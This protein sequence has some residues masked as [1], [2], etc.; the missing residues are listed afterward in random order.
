[1]KNGS[2]PAA[3]E[4]SAFTD[5]DLPAFLLSRLKEIG[6][7]RPSPIQARTIP[8]LLKGKDLVG[9]AQTGTGKTAAFAL[10]ALAKV[11]LNIR[12]PQVLV[13][14][15]TRELSM[16][17]AEAFQTYAGHLPGFSVLPVY[18]GQDY[19]IQV[20]AI[21]RGVPV[22]VGTPGRLMDHMRRGM[23]KL[24]QLSTLVLDEADEMLRMGFIDDVQWI[25]SETPATR[26]IA[27]FSATMPGPI[28]RIAKQYLNDPVT[29]ELSSKTHT[30]DTIIQRYW[31]VQG[32]HKVDALS[33]I[34]EA[35]ESDAVIVFVRTK[36]ATAEL[37][38]KLA[39]RGQSAAALNG[40]MPQQQR[41]KT[42]NRLRKGQLDI[43]VATDVAARGLDVERVSHVIN[44]DIPYDTESYVHRIGRT[45][46]AGREGN[47]ILF[48]A[49]RER[50]MLGIIE[51]AI[52]KR[53][54]KMKLPTRQ[55]IDERRAARLCADLSDTIANTDLSAQ[56]AVIERFLGENE[57][58][59]AD[60][61]AALV[62]MLQKSKP[63]T[64]QPDESTFASD[65]RRGR[66]GKRGAHGGDE[67]FQNSRK[68]EAGRPQP[69]RT[70]EMPQLEEGM[71]RFRLEVGTSHGAAAGNIVGAIANEAGI[72]SQYIGRISIHDDFSLVDLPEGM[73]KTIFK[74]LRQARVCGQ[75]LRIGRVKAGMG[76]GTP[77]SVG[78][79]KKD[80]KES[81]SAK[82]K[83]SNQ[84]FETRSDRKNQDALDF[85]EFS[86]TAE[87]GHSGNPRA[88]S[89]SARSLGKSSL[90][91]KSGKK[92]G[93]KRSKPPKRA[94][95][96]A[97]KSTAKADAKK[98]TKNKGK[99]K[100]K[101]K[102]RD[103]AS[104]A[105][106]HG[107]KKPGKATNRASSKNG[108]SPPKRRKAKA[109]HA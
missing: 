4:E 17:V 98:D 3:P 54:E 19:R 85:S 20:R 67:R 73:P 43:L 13:L 95:T 88:N 16:Q 60:V 34:L 53:I 5:L 75:A 68:P 71:E 41:E 8:A 87:S 97:A 22:V 7:E 40:D 24:D 52:G 107:S 61:A 66:P 100:P 51:K 59:G 42:I 48:V 50:R 109:V 72:D 32:V 56:K 69:A 84:S 70:T 45:G 106:K 18:G 26:Q 91:K 39:A 49:P 64:T 96:S 11:D 77:D 10:P 93:S 76:N 104:G 83:Q 94:D 89:K 57:V 38:D 58:R 14:T 27:L 2:T 74:D 80:R 79:N 63:V 65:E 37:A 81:K 62:H 90:D 105:G 21:K 15:P 46:R 31:P 25:L 35:E 102:S 30:A 99:P 23:L 36:N 78:G 101:K 86:D 82:R 6:Y 108:T 33:R 9:Q 92:P 12:A 44:F 1:M 47:A 103:S 28:K 29:V 55:D